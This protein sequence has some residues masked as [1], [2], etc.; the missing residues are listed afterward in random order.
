MGLELLQIALPDGGRFE[1]QTPPSL[2]VGEH[3][4]LVE[5][6]IKLRGIEDLEDHHVVMHR[7]EQAEIALHFIERRQHI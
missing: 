7:R 1:E 2:G 4:G 3:G 6:K 5:G